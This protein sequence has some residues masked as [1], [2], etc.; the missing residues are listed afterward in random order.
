MK[1]SRGMGWIG[2]AVGLS[3]IVAVLMLSGCGGGGG[4]GG[5]AAITGLSTKCG[6]GADRRCHCKRWRGNHND[7]S[8]R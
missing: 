2:V 8:G 5:L 4:G 1:Q 7:R 3:S 6:G